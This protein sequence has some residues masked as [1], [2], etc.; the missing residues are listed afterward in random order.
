MS[1]YL[2]YNEFK[3]LKNVDKFD[4]MSINEKNPIGF[5]LEVDLKHSDELQE[6]HN[7]Y[8]LAPEKLTVSSDK[9]SKYCKKLLISMR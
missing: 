6:L 2:P 9:L 3:W 1:E 7:D 4:A 5:F 8:P